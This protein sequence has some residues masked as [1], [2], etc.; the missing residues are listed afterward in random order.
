M[1]EMSRGW[2]VYMLLLETPQRTQSPIYNFF[3]LDQSLQKEH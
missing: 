2:G 1:R 3:N